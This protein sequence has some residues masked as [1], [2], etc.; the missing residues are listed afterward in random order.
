M[1]ALQFYKIA[2]SV[3]FILNI[4]VLAFFLS[5]RSHGPHPHRKAVNQQ[6]QNSTFKLLDLNEEQQVLFLKYA[7]KHHQEM[8]VLQQEQRTLMPT[9]FNSLI[10]TTK[11]EQAKNSILE[12]QRIE[13]EKIQTTYKHFQDIQSILT[14]EQLPRFGEFVKKA[15]GVLLIKNNKWGKKHKKKEDS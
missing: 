9:C 15:T 1:N 10:D 14:K 13:G 3:L 11:V 4:G 8:Q 5:H 7:K 2:A 6:F 12:L